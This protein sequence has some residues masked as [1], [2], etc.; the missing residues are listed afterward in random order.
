MS[1]G[2]VGLAG[3][4]QEPRAPFRLVDPG[5]EQARARDVS[6]FVA[7]CMRLAKPRRQL[8]VVLV[9]LREHLGRGNEVR[10]VVLDPLQARDMTDGAQRLP[11]ELADSLGNDVGRRE[12]LGCL[13]VEQQ[14]ICLLYTSDAADE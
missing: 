9:Q 7:K 1:S 8:N 6:V 12:N 3:L 10:I 13:I 2:V 11:S 5:L 4:E 14:V